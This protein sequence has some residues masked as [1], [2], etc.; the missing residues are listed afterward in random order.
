VP[1]KPPRKDNIQPGKAER[2]PL[3]AIFEIDRSGIDNILWRIY[4]RLQSTAQPTRGGTLLRKKFA[5]AILPVSLSLICSALLPATSDAQP[6]IEGRTNW[7]IARIQGVMTLPIGNDHAEIWNDCGSGFFDFLNFAASINVNTSGGVLG[8]FEYVLSRRYGIEL[9]F[10]W[11]RQIID[12][13]FE[14]E[15]VTVE[16]APNF[17]MPTLG[18]N[19]H[20]LPGQAADLYAGGFACLGVVATGMGTDIEVSKD[21]ALGLNLGFDYYVSGSWSIGGTIKYLDFGQM[22]FSLLPTGIDGIICDNG[23]FGIGDMNTISL[24]CGAGFRF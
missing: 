11:W 1:V 6:A 8:S 20:I 13:S 18:F 15:D 22:D 17:I 19:Y 24:T 4:I 9:G 7:G 10:Q 5:R 16:G 2:L 23:L 14:T 3:D 12:I 21:F